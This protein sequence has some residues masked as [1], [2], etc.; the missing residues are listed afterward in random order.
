MGCVP[1]TRHIQ[2]L[3]RGKNCTRMETSHRPALG[4][5]EQ[6]QL[7]TAGGSHA[8]SAPGLMLSRFTRTDSSTHSAVTSMALSRGLMSSDSP[9]FLLSFH[10]T[11]SFKYLYFSLL[12]PVLPSFSCPSFLPSW[13][14]YIA[15]AGYELAASP[16][17]LL[18]LQVCSTTQGS[19]FKWQLF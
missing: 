11:M 4:R 6:D 14:H 17:L 5:G 15:Q 13:P 2:L 9:F 16:F 10:I 7:S 12:P 1:G 8:R 3:G 18:P 19:T